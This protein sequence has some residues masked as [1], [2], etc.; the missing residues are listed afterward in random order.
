M[1]DTAEPTTR[2]TTT[3]PATGLT[4]PMVGVR[5][6]GVRWA[7]WALI[8]WE[9]TLIG[10]SSHADH[11]DAAR[12]AQWQ[13]PTAVSTCVTAA[14]DARPDTLSERLRGA[15][16]IITRPGAA[17]TAVGLTALAELLLAAADEIDKH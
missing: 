14:I 11:R 9:W 8:N 12:S 17:V 1:S 16:E 2:Y 10:S 13:A 6:A 5:R 4:V 7:A 3:H 15:A